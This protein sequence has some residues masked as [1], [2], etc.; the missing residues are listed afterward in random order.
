MLARHFASSQL[1]AVVFSS[2]ISLPAHASCWETY[3]SRNPSQYE[4]ISRAQ[5][6]DKVRNEFGKTIVMEGS[7]IESQCISLDWRTMPNY[8]RSYPNYHLESGLACGKWR[9]FKLGGGGLV[10]A[11]DF[12]VID[13]VGQLVPIRPS[14][15]TDTVACVEVKPSVYASVIARDRILELPGTSEKLIFRDID[16]LGS[17]SI[18]AKKKAPVF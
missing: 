14:R 11:G 13:K 16:I 18:Y 4:E 7:G 9:I 15:I 1:V 8:I 3:V 17:S 12:G 6:D 10:Q 5:L 2:L